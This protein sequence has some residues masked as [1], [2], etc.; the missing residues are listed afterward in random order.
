M[1]NASKIKDNSKTVHAKDKWLDLNYTW[2]Y[3]HETKKWSKSYKYMYVVT[4]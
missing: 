4:D 2:F 3:T 1:K